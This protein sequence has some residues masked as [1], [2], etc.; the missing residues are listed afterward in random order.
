MCIS[1]RS[2]ASLIRTEFSRALW[3]HETVGE[4]AVSETPLRRIGDPDDIAG[5]IV[6]LS[7][8]AARYI[9]GETIVIAGGSTIFS[10]AIST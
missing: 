1:V 4:A 3:E 10:A 7:S 2:P 5:P 6:F 8:P 9:T